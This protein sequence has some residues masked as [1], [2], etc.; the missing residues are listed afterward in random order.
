MYGIVWYTTFERISITIEYL[1]FCESHT[2]LMMHYI[3]IVQRHHMQH[4]T[5]TCET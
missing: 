4:T 3:T 1:R 2:L 5:S